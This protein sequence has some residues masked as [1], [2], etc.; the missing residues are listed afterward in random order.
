MIANP[1]TVLK[2]RFVSS[3][4]PEKQRPRGCTSTAAAIL[5]HCMDFC[6]RCFEVVMCFAEI[7]NA[8]H[9]DSALYTSFGSEHSTFEGVQRMAD[10]MSCGNDTPVT[11]R[12]LPSEVF[13]PG[14][15]RE[16]ES[17]Q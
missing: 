8:V 15:H 11:E 6:Q 17:V 2:A 1:S 3:H 14:W 9:A 16:P 10:G 7:G 12:Q 13:T 4:K 5:I